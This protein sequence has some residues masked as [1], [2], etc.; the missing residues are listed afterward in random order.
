MLTHGCKVI[1]LL[2]THG[3]KVIPLLFTHGCK[4]IPLLFT[5]GCK[6][7]PLLFTHGCKVIPLLFTHGC[8]VIPLLFTHGC[9]VI[10]LLFTHG[11]KVIPLLFTH[12]CKVYPS[13]KRPETPCNRIKEQDG[14]SLLWRLVSPAD[15]LPLDGL[16]L[17]DAGLCGLV[18]VG[19]ERL[20]GVLVHAGLARGRGELFLC[21]GGARW[22]PGAKKKGGGEASRITYK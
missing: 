13:L 20:W 3:C 6:V 10:P 21:S 14:V 18:V 9:K 7:I 15:I 16:V 19:L 12:G 4:V 17:H 8:K 22:T 2:F 1:P 5:H 11:C